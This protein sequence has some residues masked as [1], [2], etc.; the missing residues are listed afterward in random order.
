MTKT[1]V[2]PSSDVDFYGDAF[3][4]DP[5]RQYKILRGL[6][7]V[8]WLKAQQAYVLTRYDQ[9]VE[10]LRRA[11]VFISG[12][13]L[14]LNDDV[15]ALLVGNSLNTD[16]EEHRRKRSITA[17]PINPKGIVDLTTYIEAAAEQLADN[18]AERGSFDAVL[19][20][21]QILP[22]SIVT[23]LVGLPDAG[24][25][26]ML[27]WASATFNLFEGFNQR[28]LDAFD[29]LRG[30]QKFLAEEGRPGRLKEGGLAQRIFDEAPSKGFNQD[31]AAQLMRDYINP[32]LDTTISVLGFAAYHFA[33]E[34]A[35]WNILRDD[36][37]LIPNAIEELVRLSTPIRAFS[38]YCTQD[39]DMAGFQIPKDSRVIVVY[40][41][42]NRDERVFENPD[43]FDVTRN[44]R[45][46]LGFGHGVH[47]CMGLHLARLEMRSV[48][49]SMIKRVKR[50]ELEG[51]P[52]LVLN[53][54]IH[55]F[56]RLPVRIIC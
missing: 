16:G 38:R 23:E 27:T 6:G 34:P 13:G 52:T 22:Q 53:N 1:K 31:E 19:D 56:E 4:G 41:S 33:K 50:W 47:M 3:I 17:T 54:T 21:A 29:D 45:K 25:T 28:S 55:A 51:E 20:F 2:I 46:H 26:K 40:A 36:P 18:L 42:A 44:V 24:K 14:S 37:S 8:V 35:Q 11:D 43:A 7:P 5:L 49:A 48:L 32:S 9:V 39:Y 15:N 30:L 12:K 10:A